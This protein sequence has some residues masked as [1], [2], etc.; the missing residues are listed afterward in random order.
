[1]RF[2]CTCID[3]HSAAARAAVT[4]RRRRPAAIFGEACRRTCRITCTDTGARLVLTPHPSLA[5]TEGDDPRLVGTSHV[6]LSHPRSP[7]PYS[8]RLSGGQGSRVVADIPAPRI[9]RR[10]VARCRRVHRRGRRGVA[11]RRASVARIAR[12]RPRAPRAVGG[13]PAGHEQARILLRRARG[14]RRPVLPE[15]RC[16]GGDD[17]AASSGRARH[18]AHGRAAQARHASQKKQERRPFR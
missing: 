8:A 18:G 3:A 10:S 9:R 16:V 1:M 6:I 15:H 11:R 5:P 13:C 12:P 17:A 4:G 14:V 2:T 7:R